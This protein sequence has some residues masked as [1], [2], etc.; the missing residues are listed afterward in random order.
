MN[1][2]RKLCIYWRKH[3]WDILTTWMQFPTFCL[4]NDLIIW[5]KPRAVN[6][7]V[8]GFVMEHLDE[9]MSDNCMRC[10]SH[11][12]CWFRIHSRF[13]CALNIVNKKARNTFV[14]HFT[15]KQLSQHGA[16]TIRILKTVLKSCVYAKKD[17]THRVKWVF[18]RT[19]RILLRKITN[20]M[21]P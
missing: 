20:A 8:I 12:T 19:F 2:T 6:T 13:H 18:R 9:K 16:H 5:Q 11:F 14:V 10:F 7:F 3:A 4:F 15:S 17:S 1:V 21:R